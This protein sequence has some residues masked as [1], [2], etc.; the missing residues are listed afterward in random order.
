MTLIALWRPRRHAERGERKEE[1]RIAEGSDK[2]ASAESMR[3][4][5][6]STARERLWVEEDHRRERGRESGVGVETRVSAKG[7]ERKRGRE[8]DTTDRVQRQSQER[9]D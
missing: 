2:V 7:G 6:S 9:G 8:K 4:A 5:Q 1:E 3:R